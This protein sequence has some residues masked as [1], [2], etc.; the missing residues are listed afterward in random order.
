M[1]IS[2]RWLNDYVT[3]DPEIWT[4]AQVSKVL[5]DLGLEVEHI[6]DMSAALRGFVVGRVFK[7]EPHPKADKL[8][9][10]TVDVG[11]GR[12]RTIV[13]G[14]PNVEAGQL[15]PV[16]LVGAVVPTANFTIESRALR[17]ITSEG[18][19]CSQ[20]ELGLGDDHDGIWVLTTSSPVGTPLATALGIDDV[21]YDIAITPNRAD[22]LSH[23]GIAREIR[24]YELSRDVQPVAQDLSPGLLENHDQSISRDDQSIAQDL[25]FIP[26]V[27]A[28]PR[29]APTEGPLRISV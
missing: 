24:A 9:V 18:M 15:V 12:P 1:K 13:C 8:S 19:I 20:S 6:A 7:K 22:C 14:A 4:P 27:G 25:S 16:A 29:L 5:T 28:R 11:D 26:S 23:I 21:V 3:M 17:G 10:C 2:Q